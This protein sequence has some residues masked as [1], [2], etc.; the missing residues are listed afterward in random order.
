MTRYRLGCALASAICGCAGGFA[1]VVGVAAWNG[2]TDLALE[3]LGI[4]CAL[5]AAFGVWASYWR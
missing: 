4:F 5:P 1:F 2:H 3:A